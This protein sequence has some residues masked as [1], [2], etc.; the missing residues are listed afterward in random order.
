MKIDKYIGGLA[1]DL[2]FARAGWVAQMLLISLVTRVAARAAGFLRDEAGAD[3]SLDDL[4]IILGMPA[5]ELRAALDVLEAHALIMRGDGVWFIPEL[6]K[7]ADIS[8]KRSQAGRKGAEKTNGKNCV[9]DLPRLKCSN[10]ISIDKSKTYQDRQQTFTKKEKRTKKEKNNK[11]IYISSRKVFTGDRGQAENN[12]VFKGN[13]FTVFR[14]EMDALQMEF[15]G[16][17]EERLWDLLCGHDDFMAANPAISND[18][19]YIPLVS[20]LRKM[21]A[22]AAG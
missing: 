19:W 9:S 12:P 16:F 7:A 10:V 6:V 8:Y 3:L 20:G 4:G 15:P 2:R 13:S 17:G 14:R 5:G 22:K 1:A 11:Y 18:N 21:H